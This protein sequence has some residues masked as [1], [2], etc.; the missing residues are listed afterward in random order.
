M[1]G[2]N[3]ISSSNNMDRK[4]AIRILANLSVFVGYLL[5]GIVKQQLPCR[6]SLLTKASYT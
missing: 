2:G 4:F 3:I 1:L 6:Y 5:V